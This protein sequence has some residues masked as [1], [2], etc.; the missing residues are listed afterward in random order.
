MPTTRRGALLG[1]AS[2]LPAAAVQFINAAPLFF[3]R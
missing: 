3:N 1:A 2:L